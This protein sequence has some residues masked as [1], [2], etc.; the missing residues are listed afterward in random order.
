MFPKTT[1][2]GCQNT[3]Q[4]TLTTNSFQTLSLYAWLTEPSTNDKCVD[5]PWNIRLKVLIRISLEQHNI[6]SPAILDER[7]PLHA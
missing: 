3:T 4:D 6:S 1:G 5:N 7:R 2:V